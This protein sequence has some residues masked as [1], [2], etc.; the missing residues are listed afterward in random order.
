[1]PSNHDLFHCAERL[2]EEGR[3]LWVLGR[4]L[5]RAANDPDDLGSWAIKT[6]REL[7]ALEFR[8]AGVT[9]APQRAARLP[10]KVDAGTPVVAWV[11]SSSRQQEWTSVA[12]G[13][14]INGNKQVLAV[15][16]GS[17]SDPMVCRHLIKAIAGDSLRLLITDGNLTLDD[18]IRLRWDTP[19]IIA[20][21]RTDTRKG[22]LAHLQG[23]KRRRVD[24]K[25][26][27]AWSQTWPQSEESL[28][29]LL[30]DLRENHP[31]AADRL[32]RSLE[33]TLVVDKLEVQAPLREHLLVAGV[34]RTAFDA[35]VRRGGENGT[36]IKDGLAA[37]LRQTR[38][39]P[40]YRALPSLVERIDGAKLQEKEQAASQS[41][42]SK[43]AAHTPNG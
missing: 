41:L 35:A 14:D 39:L 15:V 40:G 24:E 20:H 42:T 23:E 10:A 7:Q 29:T 16:E 26:Q 37:W 27:K 2:S 34:P 32:E 30:S 18:T 22:V 9:N 25:L 5:A 3:L 36:S 12:M 28:K 21:C 38:R 6:Y 33:A 31:G 13:V 43:D 11:A 8:P 4:S 1:M 17:T 19:P